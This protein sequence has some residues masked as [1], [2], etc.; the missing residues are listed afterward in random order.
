MDYRTYIDVTPAAIEQLFYFGGF[1]NLARKY[2][3]HDGEVTAFDQTIADYEQMTAQFFEAAPAIQRGTAT[4]E[5]QTAQ[6]NLLA[7]RVNRLQT[8][9]SLAQPVVQAYGAALVVPHA[10]GVPTVH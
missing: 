3:T 7:A 9:M 8:A 6:Q 4:P 5:Q 1:I 2:G 10:N